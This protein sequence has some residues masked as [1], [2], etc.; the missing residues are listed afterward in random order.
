MK[1][2]AGRVGICQKPFALC[3]LSPCPHSRCP[4]PGCVPCRVCRGGGCSGARGEGQRV[5]GKGS[6]IAQAPGGVEQWVLVQPGPSPFGPLTYRGALGGSGENSGEQE[7]GG[8]DGRVEGS[9]PLSLGP[10]SPGGG[11]RAQSLVFCQGSQQAAVSHTPTAAALPGSQP[12]AGGACLKP[13]AWKEAG[14][15]AEV[16]RRGG[17]G[18]G[19]LPPPLPG[20]PAALGCDRPAPG[21]PRKLLT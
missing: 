9:G 14:R 2:G 12:L 18:G 15:P 17:E 8:G 4:G 3:R 5:A 19:R 13:G 21:T 11:G 7:A 20:P 10:P 16:W 6:E 1:S